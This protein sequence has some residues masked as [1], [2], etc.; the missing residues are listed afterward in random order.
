[1]CLKKKRNA[2]WMMYAR[3]KHKKEKEKKEVYVGINKSYT[4]HNQSF[5]CIS[6]KKKVLYAYDMKK[7]KKVM[8]AP[9]HINM[10]TYPSPIKNKK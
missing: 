9:Y 3:I 7:K 8:W 1:M 2:V 6:Y 10:C 5:I 4:C